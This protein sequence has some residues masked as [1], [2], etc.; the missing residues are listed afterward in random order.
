V[1]HAKGRELARCAALF[2]REALRL[3][4]YNSQPVVED[5]GMAGEYN[6]A[7]DL[8]ERNL[9]A[10][11]GAKTAFVDDAG[12]CTFAQLAERVDRFVNVLHS[13]G[14]PPRRAH[15]DRHARHLRLAGR[16]SWARSR[17]A[18]SPWR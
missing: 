14:I 4:A 13:L 1:T 2:L 7:V 15:R 9:K 8:L 3:D 18:S 11:R 10:G 5:G 16:L 6:A 12:S 17:Q